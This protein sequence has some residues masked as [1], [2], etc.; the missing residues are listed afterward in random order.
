M[1]KLIAGFMSAML[2][3]GCVPVLNASAEEV[4][5]VVFAPS[6]FASEQALYVHAVSGSKDSEA[7]QAWQSVHDER[8]LVAAP[9]EKY[10]FL[11]VS[12]G[13]EEVDVYNGFSS[14]VT[15]NGV[16]IAAGETETVPYST[17]QSYRVTAAGSTFTLRY[18]KS[19]AE[20]A[21][22]INNPDADGEGGDLM[23]YLNV[24]KSNSA[25]AT[26]AIVEADGKIDNTTIKKI[27]GRGNTS[28]DKPKKGYNITYDKKVS[29]AGM[30]KNKKYSI[31]PNYQDDSLSRNRILYDLS[32]AV[33]MPYASDSRF[34]DF[35]VNGFY[36]GSYMMTEKVE[37]GSLV[38][39]VDEEGY[40]NEDET[41]KEDFS[42]IA[43]VDAS[44]GGDD[45][46]VTCDGGI[47][48]TIKAPEIDPGNPGYEEVK[49]YVAEK[50]NALLKQCRTAIKKTSTAIDDLIDLDSAAKLYLIN[51]LGK[52][53]DAGVSSTFFTYKPDEEGKYKFYGSPVWDYDNSLGNAVGVGRD[54]TNM[55]VSDYQQYT[56]WWC[57]FKG[58]SSTEVY[59][60]NIMN[61]LSRNKQVQATAAQVW[62]ED[63]MPA[64]NH[65]SGKTK[66]PYIEPEMYS[67]DKYY[68][69]ISDSAAM[70]YKS[71]WLLNTGSWI[72]P[73]DPMKKAGFDFFTGEYTVDSANTS[74]S[75]DFMGMFNYARDWMLNRAAWLSNE[76]YASYKG[77]KVRYDVDRSG[78]FDVND[79]TEV[80]RYLAEYMELTPL[81]YELANA[82]GDEKI[83]IS[84]VTQLQ[85]IK[86]GF[87]ALVE[88]PKP[89][90]RTVT[91][92]NTLDWTGEIKAYYYGGSTA[93][94]EW[95]GVAMTPAADIDGHAAYTVELTDYTE[96]VIFNNGTVQTEKIPYDGAP[97]VYRA[98]NQTYANGRYYFT[99][100]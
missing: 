67:A 80:Q 30:E 94:F 24:D 33:G 23:S 65:F 20:A 87:S 48:V 52:N 8:F 77:S 37:A 78:E 26:G 93:P 42:F 3:F 57:R 71:G 83:N 39:D 75:G 55:G 98:V 22:Y 41:V 70:N 74:Y 92:V 91:F 64:I 81:Q 31:L 43:E 51:E 54:L 6:D 89:A 16:T 45:Y 38:T 59:T 4:E 86:A 11:P 50:F 53:W 66:N 90:N 63:F 47:K 2:V 60:Y 58:K 84:D 29:I 82:N 49:A 18:M 69:L 25:K 32:D 46:Y 88:Q 14:A 99:I 97:H 15:L 73:R 19:S 68:S 9:T 28:W 21:V 61:L 72:A 79:I 100:D 36:W 62:F 27:K 1:K 7:W 35:Y 85:R 76:M 56:G 10:F 95:P 17:E 5:E 12:A 40:L 44:A 96:Y 13:D 34:V